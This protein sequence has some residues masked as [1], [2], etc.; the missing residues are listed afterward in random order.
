[1]STNSVTFEQIW[2]EVEAVD[3]AENLA[4]WSIG[5]VYLWPIL[6]DRLIR[7]ICE[8]LG[9]FQKR[10]DTPRKPL[11]QIS[12]FSIRRS[13][14]ALVPFLRKNH[15]GQDPF[16]QPV[17]EGL[18]SAGFDPMVLGMGDADF[19][20]HVEQLETFFLAKYRGVAKTRLA[21]ALT[22]RLG[23]GKHFAKYQRVIR[24]IEASL[25][26]AGAS[27]QYSTLPRWLVVDFYAQRMGWKRLFKAAGTRKIFIVNAWKRALIAGAQSA[28]AKV[29]EIQHGLLSV[30]HPLLGWPGRD[31]IAYLPDE[32]YLWGEFWARETGL[33]SSML[34][35]VIGAPAQL[36][37]AQIT[38]ATSESASSRVNRVLLVSQA[39]Q[40]TRLFD[41]AIRAAVASPQLSFSI[42]PHP[43]ENLA[44]FSDH[45]R[46]SGQQM[47][48][49]LEIL[50][51]E[52]TALDLMAQFEFVVG[53][54]SMALVEALTLGAKVIVVKLEGWQYV[55]AIASR[56]DLILAEVNSNLVAEFAACRPAGKPDYYFATP[57]EASAFETLLLQEKP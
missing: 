22:S 41:I 20:L 29:I 21:W 14:Y 35:T 37:A 40:T 52:E 31:S 30:M 10:V 24:A 16:S 44:Q 23:G 33:P 27:G 57:M 42:K 12:A 38:R 54:H 36:G 19:D 26:A 47:P 6:R 7:E 53:V 43:Q 48:A 5:G 9:V 11:P 32:I 13:P 56:G 51:T 2:L 15:L 34:K 55:E 25:N 4:G 49:N 28:G 1:L 8:N 39:Q 18:Q 3:R 50:Q 45:L 17:L 46:E